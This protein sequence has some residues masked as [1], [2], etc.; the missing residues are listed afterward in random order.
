MPRLRHFP[1]TRFGRLVIVSRAGTRITCRCDCGAE[2]VVRLANL[3]TGHTTSC[4]CLRTETTMARST[5]HGSARRKRHTGAYQTWTD[6]LKRCRN[7]RC[8]SWP[9]YGGRGISVDPVWLDFANFL[10]NMGERPAGHTI[11]RKDPNGPYCKANCVWATRRAQNRNTRRTRLLTAKGKTQPLQAWA[12][13]LG[14]SH[15]SILGRLRRGWSVDRAVSEA[16][17]RA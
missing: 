13:E 2:R 15:T 16:S 8:K 5:K 12:D 6:M 7:P 9:D 3:T 14:V 1:G 10:A 17:C 11:E 4:G